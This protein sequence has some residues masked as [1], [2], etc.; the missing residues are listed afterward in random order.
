MDPSIELT[1]FLLPGCPHCRLALACL[2]RLLQEPRYR[3]IRV[4]R[5]DESKEKELA[6]RYDYYFVP[7]FFL[8]DVKLFEGHMELEDVKGVLEAALTA[9]GSRE[10]P[11]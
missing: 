4:R 5:V 11:A 8:G 10:Q 1:M 3:D 9:G 2:E 6:A 7:T